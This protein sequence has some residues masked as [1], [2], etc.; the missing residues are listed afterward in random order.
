MIEYIIGLF[1]VIC[2]YLF[3]IVGTSAPTHSAKSAKSVSIPDASNAQLAPIAPIAPISKHTS[4]K[5][6]KFRSK[7]KQRKFD[8]NEPSDKF[9]SDNITNITM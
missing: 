2:L 4:K 7:V 6:V 5:R 3:S 9:I 8:K 1:V